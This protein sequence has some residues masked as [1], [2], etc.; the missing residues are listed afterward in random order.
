MPEGSASDNRFEFFDLT[1]SLYSDAAIPD[2][3]AFLLPK[4]IAVS[5][6]ANKPDFLRGRIMKAMMG[7][8]FEAKVYP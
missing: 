2:L 8:D 7:H 1:S 5:G 4:A 3:K 6:A